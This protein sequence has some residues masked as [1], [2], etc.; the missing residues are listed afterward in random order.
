MQQ[1]CKKPTA[2][3][4]QKI[5]ARLQKDPKIVL[6]EYSPFDVS[7]GLVSLQ[8]V[9]TQIRPDKNIGPDLDQNCLTF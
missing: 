3:S 9:Y 7:H 1:M 4:G 2:F 5:L 6:F 8:T